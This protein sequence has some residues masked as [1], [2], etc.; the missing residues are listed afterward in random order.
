[1]EGKEKTK[2]SMWNVFTLI[3]PGPD[4]I[5]ALRSL[6]LSVRFIAEELESYV[7]TNTAPQALPQAVKT[8]GAQDHSRLTYTNTCTHPPPPSQKRKMWNG[9]AGIKR[10]RRKIVDRVR[11]R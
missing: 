6:D 11:Q 10:R 9:T 5:T 3:L 1:M 7:H 8:S 2:T 4:L